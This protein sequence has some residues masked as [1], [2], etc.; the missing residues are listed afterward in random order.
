MVVSLLKAAALHHLDLQLALLPSGVSL[1]DAT[2]YNIQF[3]GVRPIFI[4]AL[5][6]QRYED[7]DLLDS[8]S[9]VL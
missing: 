9:S 3:Q 4:D 6:F 1:S 2:A 7:G 8:A 5:S